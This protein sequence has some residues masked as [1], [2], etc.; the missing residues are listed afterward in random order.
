MGTIEVLRDG[1]AVGPGPESIKPRALLALLALQANQVLSKES[2][3]EE[4]W[5]EP[6]ASARNVIE[7]YVSLWRKVLGR[8]R[9]ETVGKGYRL[10]LSPHELDLAVYRQRLAEG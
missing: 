9:L 3:L 1:I 4:L 10:R 7:K 2:L 6:P 5:T 8:D